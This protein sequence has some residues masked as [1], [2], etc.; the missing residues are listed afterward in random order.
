MLRSW[1]RPG[2]WDSVLA[3]LRGTAL[4]LQARSIFIYR[5]RPSV[6][7]EA[8]GWPHSCGFKS[9]CPALS[10]FLLY[11]SSFPSVLG[12]ILVSFLPQFFLFSVSRLAILIGWKLDLLHGSDLL[13]VQLS[14]IFLPILT[15]LCF[16]VL[17]SRRFSP[18]F[19]SL[20]MHFKIYAIYIFLIFKSFNTS[21]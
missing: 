14:W 21:F 4:Q 11:G 15:S 8:G 20:I 17:L 10:R 16:S 19:P 18:I 9:L 12:N 6:A 1:P 2:G 13:V 3:R 5:Y 7:H